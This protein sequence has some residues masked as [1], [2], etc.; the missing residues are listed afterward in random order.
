[1]EEFRNKIERKNIPEDIDIALKNLGLKLED[2]HGDVLD[3]G[4]GDAEILEYFKDNT[5][6]N[7]IGVDVSVS[8]ELKDKVIKADVLNLPFPDNSFDTSFSHASIPNVF[9]DEYSFENPDL[10]NENVY[11]VTKRALVEIFRTLKPGGTAYLAPISMSELYDPEKAK[12]MAIERSVKELE[13][14][15]KNI[16]LD[17]Q[18]IKTHTD[19]NG[20]VRDMYR[21]IIHKI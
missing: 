18:F 4:A 20:E 5:G 11:K 7:I 21:L 19:D 17:L 6:A 14:E 2:L 12:K 3:I 9:I 13:S 15:Y 10:G 16:N 1:M 8:E